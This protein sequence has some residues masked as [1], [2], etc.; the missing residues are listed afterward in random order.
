VDLSP[1]AGQKVQLRF[2][3]VTDAAVNGEGLMVDDISVPAVNYATDFEADNGGWEAAGFA[4]VENVLPQT[5]RLAL[6]TKKSG[7]ETTVTPVTLNAENVADFPV[8]L[9]SGDTATLVVTGTT[10]FTREPA[11]YSL[12]VK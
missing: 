8:D 6:I 7:G 12:E 1:Y 9:Q 10:R 2:E 4:R 5:F 11:V 3:Y